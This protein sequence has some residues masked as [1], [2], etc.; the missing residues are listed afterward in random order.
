MM[1]YDNGDDDDRIMPS[2]DGRPSVDE[3]P[4]GLGNDRLLAALRHEH[5]EPRYDIAPELLKQKARRAIG[6]PR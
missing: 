1:T 5:G 3:T 2:R 6:Q 4:E